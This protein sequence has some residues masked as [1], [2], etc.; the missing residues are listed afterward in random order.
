MIV[1]FVLKSVVLVYTI[2]VQAKFLNVA[3]EI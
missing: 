2:D 1:D 3:Y